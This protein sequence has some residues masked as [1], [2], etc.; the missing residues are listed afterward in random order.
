[1]SNPGKW[2]I[3]LTDAFFDVG[4]CISGANCLS[5][6]MQAEAVHRVTNSGRCIPCCWIFYCCCL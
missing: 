2:N 1:M 4:V 6:C 5:C 3:K